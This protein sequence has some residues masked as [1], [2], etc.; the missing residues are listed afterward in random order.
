MLEI[1][2]KAKESS[3]CQH[4]ESAHGEEDEANQGDNTPEKNFK[5]LWIQ[6]AAQVIYESMDL[7]QTKHSKGRHVF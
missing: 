7:T 5:L 3:T 4:E 1:K 6:L 2:R